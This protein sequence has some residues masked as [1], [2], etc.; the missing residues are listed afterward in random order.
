MDTKANGLIA[1]DLEVVGMNGAPLVQCGSTLPV[2]QR[3]SDGMHCVL[4]LSDG[5]EPLAWHEQSEADQLAD[6]GR[7][8]PFDHPLYLPQSCQ[9]AQGGTVSRQP[10]I[11]YADEA[12]LDAADRLPRPPLLAGEYMIWRTL[13]GNRPEIQA[14]CAAEETVASLLNDWARALLKR[15]DAMHRLGRDETYLRHIADLALCAASERPLR[16][17]LYQRYA[18]AQEHDRVRRT[19]DTFI[20]REFPDVTWEDFIEGR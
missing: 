6:A 15:F 10:M 13:R 7:W 3:K 4:R 2:V 8:T 19:F 17:K 20:S 16:W 9:S 5:D 18:M 1:A 11:V 14:A 12:M